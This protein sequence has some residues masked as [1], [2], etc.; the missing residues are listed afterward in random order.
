MALVIG[1]V[2]EVAV[3]TSYLTSE[4]LYLCL[5]SNNITPSETDT[6]ASFT[7]V[8]GGGYA[9]IPLATGDWVIT[10][11]APSSAVQAQKTFAFTG[12]TTAPS[13]IY[14][15]MVVTAANALKWSER[16]PGANVPFT[17]I[18]GSTIKITPRL[19]C[20]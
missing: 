3:L 17:P 16:F 6:F 19:E 18:A 11:G 12:A 5:Y 10:P 2:Q 15:Y 7:E 13:T 20:S 1:N 4:I 14:G 8:A 9:R